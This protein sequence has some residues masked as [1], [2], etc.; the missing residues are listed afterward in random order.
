MS[1]HFYQV[2]TEKWIPGPLLVILNQ[3]SWS[4]GFFGFIF[5][6]DSRHPVL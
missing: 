5:K 4:A 6:G 3:N 1:M 2:T